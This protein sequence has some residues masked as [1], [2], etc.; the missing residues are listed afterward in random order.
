MGER[1]PRWV[2]HTDKELPFPVRQGLC[3]DGVLD[4]LAPTPPSQSRAMP[5]A[6][7]GQSLLHFEPGF[8]THHIARSCYIIIP[9]LAS[10]LEAR[11]WLGG[12]FLGGQGHSQHHVKSLL[13]PLVLLLSKLPFPRGA[14]DPCLLAEQASA[15]VVS[16]RRLCLPVGHPYQYRCP[17]LPRYM[18]MVTSQR[19]GSSWS[20]DF[21]QLMS[22]Y[23]ETAVFGV[24]CGRAGR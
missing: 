5:Q 17:P 9:R 15:P 1:L 2:V 22:S 16:A 24:Y 4:G 12:M 20:H 19:V 21:I 14:S 23:R 10:P 8:P 7:D 11:R 3:S 13:L 6:V 18:A